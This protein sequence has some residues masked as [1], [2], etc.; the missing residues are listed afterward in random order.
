MRHIF[1]LTRPSRG[2]TFLWSSIDRGFLHFYSHA[3][4]GARPLPSLFRRSCRIFLLTRPSR[5]ATYGAPVNNGYASDFYSHAPRGAR[6]WRTSE[7][8]L[9]FRFLLTRPSRGATDYSLDAIM[10]SLISTHTPLAGRDKRRNHNKR[11]MNNFYSH[12]PRGARPRVTLNFFSYSNFYSHAPR[13]ARPGVVGA[14]N[15]A[16]DFYSHAPRGARHTMI[17]SLRLTDNFYSHAPRGARRLPTKIRMPP[18]QIS[19]HTPLAGRDSSLPFLRREISIS[20]HTPLA[21]RDILRF[22]HCPLLHYFYSHAPRGARPPCGTVHFTNT[23][24]LLTRP[25]R[26]ATTV[27]VIDFDRLDISTHTPLA[28]RDIP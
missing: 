11:L 4:R 1:L 3:P 14:F 23:R 20:T 9:C 10:A 16:Y 13:G 2:A 6:L 18:S 8:W 7:Q 5:G 12:A 24:F 26:G 25:S 22:C 17:E 28:G 21:G 19:T 15:R 27:L